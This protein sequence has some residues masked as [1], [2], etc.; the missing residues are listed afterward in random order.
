MEGLLMV[1]LVAIPLATVE[2]QV[3]SW[4]RGLRGDAPAR[5]TVVRGDTLWDIAGRFLRH[6]WQ[7]PEVWRANPQIANPHL[8]YPGDVV[9]LRDC[10]GRPCLEV[11][12]G[13]RVVHLSP[14][15]RTLPHREAIEPI[16]LATV[17]HFLRD[18]RIVE[19]PKALA[20][21]VAGSDGRILS[22]TGDR[23]YARGRVEGSG[24]FGIYRPGQRYRDA[25]SGES[26]GLE[27]E[28]VGQARRLRQ[29][30]EVVVMEATDTHQEVR[31][32][33]LILPL[34]VRALTTDFLPRPPEREIAGQILAVPGG[35]RF[36]GRLQMVAIDL[37]TRDGLAPGHVL[38]VERRGE[39]VDEPRTGERLR[40]PG[41]EAGLVMVVR[42]YEKMSY[43]LV[44]KAT[45][46][47]AVG[48][49]LH[50]PRHA[51]HTAQR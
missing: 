5:Y 16:P 24:R 33:D 48:D 32:G 9:A 26:L 20:Y 1:L 34:E 50:N 15:M 38:S 51:L 17:R 27:L 35:V 40:L 12:R 4:D 2:A 29:A 11:E 14:E 3:P 19:H 22:G 49:R 43:A 30:E 23:F 46:P 31:S 44:M 37:G 10:D 13:R 39:W 42:P 6:P 21:V 8:I 18:H 45:R 7:W 36:I 47:L 25:A 41:E 28:S